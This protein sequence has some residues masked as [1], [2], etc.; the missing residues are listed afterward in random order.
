MKS[1]ILTILFLLPLNSLAGTVA[2]ENNITVEANSGGNRASPGGLVEGQA[3]ASIRIKTVLNGEVIEDTKIQEKAT[4]SSS[5][6]IKTVK[7]YKEA[8][9]S[10]SSARSSASA[11]VK[12]EG[13]T[14]RKYYQE[15]IKKIIY[16]V[17]SIFKIF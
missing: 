14:R 17:L 9:S 12:V 2:V 7:N 11:E 15:F 13:E 1:V 5:V 16:R 4:G 3:E 6:L 8:S 10:V